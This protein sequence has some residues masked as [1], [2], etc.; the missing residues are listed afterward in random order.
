M[1]EQGAAPS[2]GKRYAQESHNSMD[3]QDKKTAAS[4][5]DE[6]ALELMK[7]IA[8]STGYGKGVQQVGFSSTGTR[9]PEEQSDALLDLFRKCR[10]VVREGSEAP[11][12]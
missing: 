9:S 7:F 11:K 2:P 6:V 3:E 5:G 12:L 10:T 4:T 8:T 1:P